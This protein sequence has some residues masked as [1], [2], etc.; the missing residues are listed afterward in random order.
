[1]SLD[2]TLSV[3]VF[4]AVV[5]AWTVSLLVVRYPLRFLV[6]ICWWKWTAHKGGY[7]SSFKWRHW[8]YWWRRAWRTF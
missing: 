1:M 4:L 6:V 5:G 8:R 2:V 7:S 3:V